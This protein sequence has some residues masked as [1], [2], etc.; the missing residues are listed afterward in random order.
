MSE[1]TANELTTGAKVASKKAATAK[2]KPAAKATASKA[3]KAASKAAKGAAK[4]KPRTLAADDGR[5][6]PYRFSDDMAITLAKGQENSYR[7][8][9]AIRDAV[10]LA[11]KSKT[12]GK[13]KAALGKQ[14]P[15]HGH[16]FPFDYLR[17]AR[18]EGVVKVG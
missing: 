1:A 14:A 18:R 5:Y 7:E 3:K 2:A 11:L 16:K 6:N 13:F 12:V 9:S 17:I 4:A 10:A 8:G 15:E